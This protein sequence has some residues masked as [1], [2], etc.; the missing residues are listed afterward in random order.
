ME[1][2]VSARSA[3]LLVPSDADLLRQYARTR[4]DIAFGRVVARHARAVRHVAFRHTRHHQA[5]EDVAQAAFLVMAQRPRSALRSARRKRSALPWLA[6]VCRYAANNWRRAETRRQR[7]EQ[8][9]A[10]PATTFDPTAG[11]DLAEAVQSALACLPRRE[12][13]IV[14]WRHLSQMS[15]DD[16]ARHAGTSPEAARKAGTRALGQL[17]VVLEKRGITAG[18]AAVLAG[19]RALTTQTTTHAATATTAATAPEL[20]AGVVTMLK[21]QAAAV[22]T[23]ATLATGGL[24]ATA[25]AFLQSDVLPPAT[26]PAQRAGTTLVQLSNGVGIE[27]VALSDG[28]RTWSGDGTPLA[29]QAFEFDATMAASPSARRVIGALLRVVDPLDPMDRPTLLPADRALY[30]LRPAFRDNESIPNAAIIYFYAMP[31]DTAEPFLRVAA[32]VEEWVSVGTFKRD[33]VATSRAGGWGNIYWGAATLDAT[34]PQ[35]RAQSVATHVF[36]P[37]PDAGP[38]RLIAGLSTGRTLAPDSLISRGNGVENSVTRFAYEPAEV[39]EVFQFQHRPAE[40]AVFG[41]RARG[42]GYAVV[43]APAKDARMMPALQREDLHT[44]VVPGPIAFDAT[45]L[46]TVVAWLAKHV[47]RPITIRESSL[48]DHGFD[49]NA[50]ITLA[51]PTGVPLDKLLD[52]VLLQAGQGRDGLDYMLDG[53]GAITIVALEPREPSGR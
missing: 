13:R 22:V 27:L 20:A 5:A 35:G 37:A 41:I 52:L 32:A 9:A 46:T 39:I 24:I 45:P 16:V 42:D 21:L 28:Q 7:R 30:S 2:V 34:A 26:R 17:R 44:Q 23:A 1:R 12:R 36:V 8:A 48:R 53:T 19:L 47:D 50:P 31:G 14:E 43:A 33:E 11:H 29:N 51:V 18:S 38:T 3:N 15:W 6:K 10:R 40:A 25:A 49:P 4:D